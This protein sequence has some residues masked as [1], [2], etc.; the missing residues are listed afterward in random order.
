[1]PFEKSP[2]S[3]EFCRGWQ[4]R[5]LIFPLTRRFM[6]SRNGRSFPTRGAMCGLRPRLSRS[7][8]VTVEQVTSSD[9]R[10]ILCGDSHT[11]RCFV[12]RRDLSRNLNHRLCDFLPQDRC[13]CIFCLDYRSIFLLGCSCLRSVSRLEGDFRSRNA[14]FSASKVQPDANP[15]VSSSLLSHS[16]RS[17]TARVSRDYFPAAI[18]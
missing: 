5:A 8:S 9:F 13:V 2:E 1:M 17:D 18:A 15:Q 6:I 14:M 7:L 4:A 12:S 11:S 10:C 3:A 16:P